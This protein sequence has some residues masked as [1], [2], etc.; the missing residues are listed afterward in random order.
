MLNRIKSAGFDAYLVGGSVRD[1]LLHKRPKDFDVATNATPADIRKLFRNA[2]IIGRRFKL[3]HILFYREVIEVATFRAQ[4]LTQDTHQVNETGMLVRDNEFGSLEDD[5]WRRDFTINSM[6]YDH[7]NSSII[8]ITD[9]KKDI[10]HKE[11]RI[12]GD[13]DVRYQEDPVRMLRAVRFAAKLQ[14]A[15]EKHTA[16]AIHD[17]NHL[18]THVSGSRLFDEITKLYQCGK[19]ESVHCLL[20][21]YGLFHHLFPGTQKLLDEKSHYPINAFIGIALES[22][23]KRIIDGKPVNPA[24]LFAVFLWFPLQQLAKD[25]QTEG[26]NPL[27]AVEKAMSTVISEQNKTVFV[28]KKFAQVIREIWIMQYRFSKRFGRR[29]FTLLEH[30]RFRAAY[31]FLALR[32]LAGDETMELANWWTNFQDLDEAGQQAMIDQIPTSLPGKKKRKRRPAK[33]K[34]NT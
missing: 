26:L 5:A 27:A 4:G 3:V 16:K 31:D 8:D 29:P 1:L 18:I 24:F 6:Y 2:R 10:D 32:A 17:N 19:S 23:D 9:G 13:A 11:V 7:M 30:P 14:F 21:E 20:S 22:T 25:L 34:S 15:I 33:P 28:S 12:I